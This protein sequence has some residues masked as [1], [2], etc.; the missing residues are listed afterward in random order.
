MHTRNPKWPWQSDSSVFAVFLAVVV[1]LLLL[2]GGCKHQPPVIDTEENKVVE[3]KKEEILL[4]TPSPTLPLTPLPLPSPTLPLTPSPSPSPRAI[5]TPTQTPK[6]KPPATPKAKTP[7]LRLSLE[8]KSILRK[9][10][11]DK[12]REQIGVKEIGRTNTGPE[13]NEYLKA[14]GT[15]PGQPWCAAFNAW[16]YKV[17]GAGKMAPMSA[18]SP[19]WVKNPTWTR[20]SGG[21]TPLPGSAF[22]LY[23]VS[24]KR[25]A[26]TGLIE[27]WGEK[28]VVT[29]EGNTTSG[30][31]SAE[32]ERNGGGV[33]R[34][35]RDKESIHS[36]RDW[37]E[38][39]LG[40][41]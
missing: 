23:Y 39:P 25:I 40:S 15:A 18:W 12:A 34:R 1:L 2:V 7:P 9:K 36:V 30:K 31:A 19:D 3:E 5:P 33:Y 27:T 20:S 37:V 17:C 28:G 35:V 14:T 32:A 13:V 4:P 10:I 16:V 29:I 41:T 11:V 8:E 26:H 24:R 21:M 38:K 22:G 6:P